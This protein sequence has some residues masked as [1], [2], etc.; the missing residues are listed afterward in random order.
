MLKKFVFAL[1]LCAGMVAFGKDYYVDSSHAGCGDDA[2]HGTEAAPFKTV[3]YA[4]TVAKSDGD[5]VH[6]AAGSYTLTAAVTLS[7]GVHLIGAGADTTSLANGGKTFTMKSADALV[8]GLH[9]TGSGNTTALTMSN[10]TLEECRITGS[11]GS[12]TQTAM[13]LSVSGGTVVNCSVSGGGSPNTS[14][15]TASYGPISVSGNATFRNCLFTKNYCAYSSCEAYNWSGGGAMYVNPGSGKTVTFENCT[16]AGNTGGHAGALLIAAESH[17]AASGTVNI[18]GCVFG[19]NTTWHDSYATD[20]GASRT[21]SIAGKPSSLTVNIENS[22]FDQFPRDAPSVATMTDSFVG[23]VGFKDEFNGDYTLVAGSYGYEH[24][25]NAQSRGEDFSCA[26][27]SPETDRAIGSVTVT[28]KAKLFNAPEGAV[29]YE[30]DLDGDGAYETTDKGATFEHTFTTIGWNAVGLRVTAGGQTREYACNQF[31]YVAPE[32]LVVRQKTKTSTFTP[33]FPYATEDT[34]SETLDAAVA[35]AL[36]GCKIRVME[37]SIAIS[38]LKI[39]R[40]VEIFGDNREKSILKGTDKSNAIYVYDKSL[41]H[42]LT[43]QDGGTII[44]LYGDSVVSNCTVFSG[45][46]ATGGSGID[47]RHGL[48]THSLVYE[49]TANQ[50]SGLGVSLGNDAVLRNSII[51]NCHCTGSH[52]STFSYGAV[53]VSS[54]SA[55]VE[56][57]TI[58][59]NYCKGSTSYCGG[60]YLTAAGTVRNCIIRGNEANA[61]LIGSPADNDILVKSGVSAANVYNNCIPVDFGEGC[62]TG[63]PGFADVAKYDFSI[64][65]ASSCYNK[66]VNQEWM[67]DDATDY[68]GNVR[69]QGGTVDIGAYEADASVLVLSFETSVPV[70]AGSQDITFTVT[71]DYGQLP[72]GTV[73]KWDF[74]ND[75]TYEFETQDVTF[76]RTMPEGASTVSM[77]AGDLDPVTRE[78]AVDI[79]AEIVYVVTTAN[80]NAAYPYN[81]WATAAPKI[82]VALTAAGNGSTVILTN[83]TH[84]MDRAVQIDSSVT[85]RGLGG[86]DLVTYNFKTPTDGGGIDLANPGAVVEGLTLTKGNRQ[87]LTMSAGTIRDC[88]VTDC[89]GSTHIGTGIVA[90]G[91]LIDRVWVTDCQPSSTAEGSEGMSV[92]LSGS[93]ILRNSIITGNR[94]S[95]GAGNSVV[96]VGSGCRMENCTVYGNRSRNP[97]VNCVG[98]AVVNSVIFGNETWQDTTSAGAPNWTCGA[99]AVFSNNVSSAV[100]GETD[101]TGDPEFVDPAN[102]DFTFDAGS[103]CFNAGCDL[104]WAAEAKDYYGNPRL[105]GAAIDVG[106]FEADANAPNVSIALSTT[107][108]TGPSVVVLSAVDRLR[109]R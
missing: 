70:G 101:I 49:C 58:Y 31:A 19:A 29:T 52:A 22:V 40:S 44:N 35:A 77:K 63:D 17:A 79:K 95:S 10:G 92:H 5:V 98:G 106:A 84:T 21:I 57:C 4:L 62:Q 48:V 96:Y 33:T 47:M 14:G 16:F 30:W 105:S 109:F 65:S 56:N 71:G 78:N 86:R 64:T 93:A 24:G 61:G 50:G 67:T 11:T 53:I 39:F 7:S 41:L 85:V 43:F 72:V 75:G 3:A 97:A 60:V 26:V 66:G 107:G 99:N 1:A 18:R 68:G 9:L 23:G 36:D 28:L 59:G 73:Y 80:P 2:S 55:V 13:S 8:K 90:S 38:G 46:V 37:G 54:A 100:C 88:K 87:S 6:V 76:T 94:K 89:S 102:G 103:V 27:M 81:T 51:R 74:D 45:N 12:S 108:G 20:A 25:Y 42:T 69:L 82:S 15:V 91:G 104:D 34:A 32:T 83:G